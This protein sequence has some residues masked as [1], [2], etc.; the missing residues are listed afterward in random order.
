MIEFLLV[1]V[2][3]SLLHSV[4]QVG[5]FNCD[6]KQLYS[7]SRDLPSAFSVSKLLPMTLAQDQFEQPPVRTLPSSQ[8]YL[9]GWN[10]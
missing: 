5:A 9:K 4:N 7:R 8:T 10:T 2:Q 3:T 6:A 1:Y